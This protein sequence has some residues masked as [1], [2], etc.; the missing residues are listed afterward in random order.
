MTDQKQ[1]PYDEFT[2]ADYDVTKDR[3]WMLPQG[4]AAITELSIGAKILYASLFSLA[5][6][7]GK[8]FAYKKTLKG[9]L[10]N[11]SERTLLRWQNE[12]INEGLLRV[13]QK[14]RGMANTYYFLRHPALGNAKVDEFKPGPRP[15]YRDRQ[16]GTQTIVTEE[17]GLHIFED[18]LREWYE[19]NVRGGFMELPKPG[20]KI[21]P[22]LRKELE[23]K[24]Q[25]RYSD[26][27]INGT[28]K[29]TVP[30]EN[31]LGTNI[32][33]SEDVSHVITTVSS[34]SG[35]SS[36]SQ[37]QNTSSASLDYDAVF[38]GK[39]PSGMDPIA[40]KLSNERVKY[41]SQSGEIMT[42]P[43]SREC[44]IAAMKRRKVREEEYKKSGF[45]GPRLPSALIASLTQD[46]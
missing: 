4:V 34:N 32:Q 33:S 40:R 24:W 39:F 9:Y 11:P 35:Y 15:L 27:V 12:L 31:E 28:A 19:V 16:H 17:E 29:I 22:A 20:I 36:E 18:R 38:K 8:A 25:Q 46:N 2:P 5:M 30:G 26:A 23:L 13:L 45:T 43:S 44:Y 41:T 7:Y 37:A 14:G 21:K 3:Y 10:G 1:R 42:A 6:K